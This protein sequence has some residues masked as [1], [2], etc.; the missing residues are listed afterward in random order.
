MSTA[1]IR[2]LLLKSEKF[3]LFVSCQKTQHRVLVLQDLYLFIYFLI[4]NL[5]YK[6]VIFVPYLTK[7]VKRP[8]NSRNGVTLKTLWALLGLFCNPN[9]CMFE[10]T[11]TWQRSS[12][13]EHDHDSFLN[14]FIIRTNCKIYRLHRSCKSSRRKLVYSISFFSFQHNQ[15]KI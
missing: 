4:N 5:S 11:F 12:I 3:L 9:L 6:C 7:S 10:V 1:I 13:L 14:P 2:S 8:T 15:L